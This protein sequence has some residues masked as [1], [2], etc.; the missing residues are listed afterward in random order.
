P[1]A[2][3]QPSRLGWIAD[4][5][6]LDLDAWIRCEVVEPVRV[7]VRC[8]IGGDEQERATGYAVVEQ[9][10]CVRFARAAACR[11]EQQ[12]RHAPR[13]PTTDCRSA[14]SGQLALQ[15]S[16]DSGEADHDRARSSA[17]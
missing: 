12:H 6:K 7:P 8:T 17:A 3:L 1:V 16:E 9:W 15:A 5:V 11:R 4:A 2:A 10:S 14:S 13:D